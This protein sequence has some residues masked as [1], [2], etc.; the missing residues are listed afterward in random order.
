MLSAVTFLTCPVEM[1][2]SLNRLIYMENM[3]ARFYSDGFEDYKLGFKKRNIDV[4]ICYY[5]IFL[6]KTM[7]KGS[8]KLK[9][10]Q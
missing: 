8:W 6:F 7:S 4:D 9:I 2:Y 3:R 1:K 5:L 10:H